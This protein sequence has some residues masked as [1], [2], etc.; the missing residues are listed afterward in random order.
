M[1]GVVKLYRL[2]ITALLTTLL[3]HP[4]LA[5]DSRIEA[6]RSNSATIVNP[7]REALGDTAYDEAISSGRYSYIGN[8][9]CRMCHK[10]FVE[11]RKADPHD[12]AFSTLI[13]ARD[14]VNPRCLA[15]HSTGHGTPTGFVSVP[16]TP[17]LMNVQCEGC[18][19]PGS[20]HIRRMGK[21]GFLA[22]PDH[23]EILKRM[24]LSCH[25]ERWNRAFSN[26]DEAYKSYKQAKPEASTVSTTQTP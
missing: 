2:I 8:V 1:G 16:E 26:F 9:K 21:G 22:G 20:E 25:N 24:C 7:L 5:A 12:H 3:H 10:D 4:L 14:A 11:G 17:R 23:P 15:C 19:G 6:E 13:Q 18:H